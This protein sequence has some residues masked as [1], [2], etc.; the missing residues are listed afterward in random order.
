MKRI[1]CWILASIFLAVGASVAVG[2]DA[3]SEGE[4]PERGEIE[5]DRDSFTPATTT[6]DRGRSVLEGSYTFI[7]N[8]DVPEGHSFPEL[9]WRMGVSEQLE[10]RLGW[11]FE[12]GGPSGGTSGATTEDSFETE[13][14]LTESASE[15]LYGAKLQTTR[16]SDWL[17]ET[18]IILQGYTPTSG[19]SSL[20]RMTVGEAF[21]WTLP[22]DWKWDTAIRFGTNNEEGDAFN[23]WAPS[24]VVKIPVGER[25]NV[26]AEYFSL[27]SDGKADETNQ[28]YGSFGAHVLL[29]KDVELGVRCGFG[30]NEE[31]AQF[32]N[33]VGLGWQF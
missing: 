8:R 25:W 26:H 11:N 15:M 12:T 4:S 29:T 17:P 28:H 27:L 19:P 31:A 10:L 32:F 6:V 1:G 5:T 18:A 2:Q 23:Q 20:S 3:V 9:L 33:N 14:D 13:G 21:G 24:T 7:D 22:N 16:Q 30:L